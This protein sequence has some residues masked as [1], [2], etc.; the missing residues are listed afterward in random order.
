MGQGWGKTSRLTEFSGQWYIP[1][2][3]IEEWGGLLLYE[4][5]PMSFYLREP[6]PALARAGNGIEWDECDCPLCGCGQWLPL[7][8]APDRAEGSTGLRFM[9]VCCQ[10]C[11]LCFTNPRPSPLSMARFYRNEYGP[12][13]AC[14]KE[15]QAPRWWQR[16]PGLG[17]RMD[18][19]RKALPLH[20]Q[21]RLLDFGCGSGSFLA[22]MHQQGWKVTGL[23]ASEAAVQRVRE[24][25]LHALTGTLPHPALDDGSFDVVTM[26][27][28]LEHVHEPMPVLQAACRVLAA[29]GKLIVAV[30][31][32]DSLAFRWFGAAWNGLDLPRHL[33]HFTP[34]T[35]RQ[36]LTRAGF[37][38]GRV[39]MVR[40]SG[41]LRSSARFAAAE[42]PQPTR[43]CRWLQGRPLANLASWYGYCTRQADCMM[44]T[45]VRK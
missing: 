21:G 29:G 2:R 16:W 38:V 36:M 24:L 37:R 4:W 8:E 26:W 34:R 7:I 10:D 33:T 12:H 31:N 15:W 19:L 45:A 5:N 39:R 17:K 22:R 9:V 40:R 42:L 44:V 3:D 25:G 14:A 1:G 20:G 35:L 28:A 41:W 13:Q 30:P 32:L 27:Q 18:V 43:W 11:G 23:D 6:A